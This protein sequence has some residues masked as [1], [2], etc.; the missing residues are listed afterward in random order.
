MIV[1]IKEVGLDLSYVSFL[2]FI[3]FSI[4]FS[5]F[6]FLEQLRLGLIGHAVTSVTI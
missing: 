4:Y 3:F 2:L 5:I 6:Y 1:K